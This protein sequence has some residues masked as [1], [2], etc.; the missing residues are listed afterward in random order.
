MTFP[1]IAVQHRRCLLA[2]TVARAVTSMIQ[3]GPGR[4]L[5][6][7]IKRIERWIEESSGQLRARKLSA[8]AKRDLD[9]SFSAL[10]AHIPVGEQTDDERFFRWAA[11][12]W[13]ALTLVEDVH[14]TCPAFRGAACWRYLRRTLNTLAENLREMEPDIAEAGTRIYE[15][16]A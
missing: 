2:V 9:N 3:P 1:T 5:T 16:A 14:H 6:Q 15:E 8:G 11:L 7:R 12:V 10:A 13:A 4:S